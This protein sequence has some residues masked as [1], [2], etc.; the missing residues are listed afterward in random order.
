MLATMLFDLD[1]TLVDTND[2]IIESF[3]HVMSGSP[4]AHKF[5]RGYIAETMG[6]RLR[7]QLEEYTGT[8]EVDDLI[9]TY[10]AF[11][12]ANHDRL[13]KP[14]PHMKETLKTLHRSG[15]RL[16]VVTSKIRTTVLMGLEIAGL[17]PF[18]EVIVSEEDVQQ[19]KPNAEPVLK[20]LELLKSDSSKALMVGD[21][22]YDILAAKAAGVKSAAVGWSLKGEAFLKSYSPDYYIRDAWELIEIA[23]QH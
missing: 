7:E 3:M 4:H 16:G 19:G 15:I 18:I 23:N 17:L 13:V 8:A 14:F 9:A 21:S 1:G 22:H 11:N 2:L 12:A 6:L 10:R 5:T 20:A